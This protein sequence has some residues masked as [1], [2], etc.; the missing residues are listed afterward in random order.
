MN[1]DVPVHILPYCSQCNGL[2]RPHI[3]W[4]GESV[5]PAD[6]TRSRDA[7]RRCDVLLVIGTSGI[8]QPAA[9]FA[10]VAK[11]AGAYVVEV[12]IEATSNSD[13]VD[14]TLIGRASEIVPMFIK[15]PV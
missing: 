12:N 1:E 6:I 11:N 9:S 13:L 3:V 14:E 10:S 2:L 8:V 5:D 4:F 7:L 15:G